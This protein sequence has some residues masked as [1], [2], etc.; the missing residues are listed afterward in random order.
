MLILSLLVI[1]GRSQIVNLFSS[2]EALS[3]MT[4]TAMIVLGIRFLPV[5]LQGVFHGPI[6]A[7]GLQAR[8]SIVAFVSWIIVGLP[9]GALLAF[10]FEQGL[11][12]LML[13]LTVAAIVQLIAYYLILKL[14]N[15]HDIAIKAKENREAES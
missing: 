13:G 12:G 3:E 7:L 15:W 14:K 1:L 8:G 6:R 11:F 2:D 9:T 4:E 5:G 10:K